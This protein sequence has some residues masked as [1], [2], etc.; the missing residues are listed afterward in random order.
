MGSLHLS[1]QVLHRLV[2][3][4]VEAPPGPHTPEEAAG[5]LTTHSG[6][7]M[8]S[9]GSRISRSYGTRLRQDATLQTLTPKPGSHLSVQT[10]P[11]CGSCCLGFTSILSVRPCQARRKLS[12]AR[13]ND[14][15]KS[16][17]A[18]LAL[19]QHGDPGGDAGCAHLTARSPPGPPLEEHDKGKLFLWI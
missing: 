17:C 18:G 12:P 8:S 16:R 19:C 7:A 5:A 3:Q 2:G 10:L 11:P 14:P 4:E 6:V 15:T 13:S 9:S 1:R